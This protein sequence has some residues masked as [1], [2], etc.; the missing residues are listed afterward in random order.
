MKDFDERNFQ[1]YTI[2]EH[3]GC[4]A[5]L[6]RILRRG[7]DVVE[8]YYTKYLRGAHVRSLDTVVT[9]VRESGSM[10]KENLEVNAWVNHTAASMFVL[11]LMF[12]GSRTVNVHVGRTRHSLINHRL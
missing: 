7:R 6:C 3:V 4:A 5:E 8:R 1:D 9:V 12:V 2:L 11:V 10:S